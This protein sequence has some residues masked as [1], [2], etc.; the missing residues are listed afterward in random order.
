MISGAESSLPGG[1]PA[2]QSRAPLLE[3]IG[4]RK[5]FGGNVA[6]A[7]GNLLVQPGEIHGLL[8]ENGAGKSTMIRCL[9]RITVPDAG[10]IRLG[11]EPLPERVDAR[12]GIA[13]IHQET[14]LV[15]DLSVAENIALSI[16]YPRRRG[17]IDWRAV[18][19]AARE[20]LAVAH[21]DLD[22]RQVVAELPQATRTAVAIARAVT[23]K[24]RVFVLDEPTAN[25]GATEVES[26]FQ[27]LFRLR[28]SGAGVVLVSHRLDEVYRLCDRVTV[29]RD[30]HTVGAVSLADTP[31]R[32]L[33]R[34]ITGHDVQVP[35]HV[36][37]STS[38][39]PTLVGTQ[40]KGE[41]VGP[42]S[43]E[44]RAGEIVGFTGLTDAG[45]Y[46]LGALLFGLGAVES[47][48]LQLHGEPYRPT[49]PEDAMRRDV[50]YVPPDRAQDGIAREMTLAENL[51]LN[52]GPQHGIY[53][54]GRFLTRRRE[55]A[56]AT[57][58]LTR[59]TVRPPHPDLS[60]GVLSGGNAQKVLVAR[61]LHRTPRLIILNDLT[62]GV[63]IGAR[64]DIY[65]LIAAAA[66]DGSAVIVITSDFEEIET[67]CNRAYVLSRGRLVSEVEE[68]SLS[69]R[70]ITAL[71]L[72]GGDPPHD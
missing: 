31:Q 32:E 59:F 60:V 50:G 28:D 71:A 52:P 29:L 13:F 65:E 68:A 45:H 40:V 72:S 25:L 7:D 70:S 58:I 37:T 69:V 62:Q 53:A 6:L 1:A 47:G 61:W 26:L 15:E 20:A 42:V 66:R 38:S 64:S 55:R 67:L 56:A 46:R 18:H 23:E 11:G 54:G 4:L 34:L 10:L 48:T 5:V 30:G 12:G 51:F 8:G 27:I 17:L 49:G 41:F 16:G 44:V 63:D 2:G 21:I 35:Q 22:P 57:S 39:A 3:V 33:V 14:G 19:T 43:F 9:A 24:A 36:S